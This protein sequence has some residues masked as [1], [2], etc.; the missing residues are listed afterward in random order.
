MEQ[1]NPK[2]QKTIRQMA[3]ET[4][5]ALLRFYAVLWICETRER[6]SPEAGDF[7]TARALAEAALFPMQ[8]IAK[9]TNMMGGEH[10]PNIAFCAA[11]DPGTL[12]ECRND[13]ALIELLD[14]EITEHRWRRWIE[15]KVPPWPR[16]SSPQWERVSAVLS[17]SRGEE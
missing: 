12:V 7:R 3:I 15:E 1:E 8:Q 11:E 4:F 6:N 2:K 14:E 10:M 17:Q 13:L 16:P 9:G 5:D